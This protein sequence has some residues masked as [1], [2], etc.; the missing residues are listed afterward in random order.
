MGRQACSAESLPA[1][2]G[3]GRGPVR[4]EVCSGGGRCRHARHVP[5]GSGRA[6]GSAAQRVAGKSL[7]KCAR[8]MAMGQRQV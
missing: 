4:R 5:A 2:R 1:S 6:V 8:V 7:C 3:S